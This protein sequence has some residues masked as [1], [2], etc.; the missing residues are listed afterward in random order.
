M[1][2]VTTDN[3]NYQDIA[4]KIRSLAGVE[5]TYEPSKMPTGIES[6]YQKGQEAANEA[7]WGS[8][9]NYGKPAY[10]A[11]SFA[12]NRWNDNTFYPKYNIVSANSSAIEMFK[13]SEITDLVGRLE[14]CGVILDLSNA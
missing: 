3:K 4:A 12:G 6:V 1:A 14:E 13:E 5:T 9:L 2:I 7:F 11:R 10:Y 8:Y